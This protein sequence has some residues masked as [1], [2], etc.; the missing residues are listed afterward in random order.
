[1]P[2]FRGRAV[3]V[4]AT[5]V[6]GA[7]F[8]PGAASAAAAEPV[9]SFTAYGSGLGLPKDIRVTD[10]TGYFTVFSDPRAVVV[11]VDVA[12]GGRHVARFVLP[13]GATLAPGGYV[14]DADA[15]DDTR[16]S[17][18]ISVDSQSCTKPTGRFRVL[19]VAFD[20]GQVTRFHAVYE[21]HCSAAYASLVGE[22]RYRVPAGDVVVDHAVMDLPETY[23]GLTTTVPVRL[24]NR[25]GGALAVGDATF[26]GP[27]AAA[28]HLVGDDCDRLAAGATCALLVGFRP[29]EPGAAYAATLT[30]SAGDTAYTA[31]F[32]GTSIP[33]RSLVAVRSDPGDY[34]G[35]GGSYDFTPT[36]SAFGAAV[37]TDY[38]AD[39]MKITVAVENPATGDDVRVEVAKASGWFQPGTTYT[40]PGGTDREAPRLS[41][42]GW[43]RGCGMPV[44]TFTVHDLAFTPGSMRLE[45]LVLTVDQRCADSSA[46]LRASVE[47]RAPL[48]RSS[49]DVTPP[50]SVTGFVVTP[51]AGSAALSWQPSP[52]P[53]VDRYVVRVKVG[54]DPASGPFSG[55]VAYSGLDTSV[56]VGGLLPGVTYTFAVWAVDEWRNV[57]PAA[58]ATLYGS[59]LTLTRGPA[60]V[61][62]GDRI[63][64]TVRLT[65]PD[66]GG[67]AV[68]G[69]TVTV[70]HRPRGAT[71]FQPLATVTTGAD[72]TATL[73]TVP[74]AN[75]EYAATWT[76]R[77]DTLGATTG[78]AGVLVRTR[79]T[80]TLSSATITRT[81]AARLVGRVAPNHAGQRVYLQRF[82]AGA[83]RTVASTLLTSV[84]GYAFRLAPGTRGT[85]A[86][87]VV[88]A[89][90]A[91]HVTGYAPTRT[92]TVT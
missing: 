67:A 22:V 89:S 34:V 86:Y 62:Y 8:V 11:H 9:T 21:Q 50:A 14:D 74:R 80:A 91:D 4:A 54:D 90:D 68:S 25:G 56:T 88:K 6:I 55:A 87:R 65:V 85:F 73:P 78:P 71:A 3:V 26:A 24:T 42:G 72:G 31:T 58:T 28:F 66:A 35:N 49:P 10:D 47:W 92:L 69:A 70:L 16:P 12:G 60:V 79:L 51:G 84:S 32:T 18:E 57:S 19:D 81:G 1:M 37:M 53:D 83:W 44:G 23:P 82:S 59:A 33:G 15:A 7:A 38:D 17:L 5:T 77:A 46:H 2:G 27:D 13:V 41:V 63:A 40:A 29:T 61:V 48:D 64:L 20:A 39:G 36:D 75:V 52:S 76:G 43:G 30:V 45:R